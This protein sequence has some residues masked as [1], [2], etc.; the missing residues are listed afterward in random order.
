MGVAAAV[1]V[2][3]KGDGLAAARTAVVLELLDPVREILEISD[4]ADED[5]ELEL[6][7]SRS[8][9]LLALPLRVQVVVVRVVW[10]GLRRTL[11]LWGDELAEC[12]EGIVDFCATCLLDKRVVYFA[13]SLAGGTREGAWS[14]TA[15]LWGRVLRGVLVF[16]IV[17]RRDGGEVVREG[18]LCSAGWVAGS[19]VEVVHGWCDWTERGGHG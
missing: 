9:W 12:R 10:V 7:L 2:S 16:V 3:G 18:A 15:A 19:S 1:P 11:V 4:R 8:L 17:V 6:L 13:L 14:A 5:L